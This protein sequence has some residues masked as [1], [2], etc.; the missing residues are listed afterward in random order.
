MGWHMLGVE[1]DQPMVRWS[2]L[3]D[4]VARKKL[5]T[6]KPGLYMLYHISLG[7]QNGEPKQP[8]HHYLNVAASKCEEPPLCTVWMR[9]FFAHLASTGP[10][11][12][13]T[14]TSRISRAR[15]FDRLTLGAWSC[16]GTTQICKSARLC[17]CIFLQ[18]DAGIVPVLRIVHWFGVIQSFAA[19]RK[20][21]PKRHLSRI[22]PV[23]PNVG[24]HSDHSMAIWWGWKIFETA[25]Q[26]YIP[27]EVSGWHLHILFTGRIMFNPPTS[28]S[29]PK[30]LTWKL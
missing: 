5:V 8:V 27:D 1:H 13:L 23:P 24:K 26:S 6:N 30:K 22:W 14:C 12:F 11:P 20:Q 25:S 28:Y 4:L 15:Q 7:F 17:L 16:F 18:T 21:P 29:H 3:V 19:Q 9:S 10:R 2:G